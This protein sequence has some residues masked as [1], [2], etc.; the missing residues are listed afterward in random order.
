M[1]VSRIPA[2]YLSVLKN[3]L[4]LWFRSQ[5]HNVIEDRPELAKQL[6]FWHPDSDS[7]SDIALVV[8]TSGDLFW[9]LQSLCA[10]SCTPAR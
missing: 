8:L 4:Q 5:T 2:R 9:D 10:L 6:F 3:E 7:S 1:A